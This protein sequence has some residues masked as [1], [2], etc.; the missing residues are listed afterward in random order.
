MKNIL[1]YG[2]T[3]RMV[4]VMIALSWPIIRFGKAWSNKPILKWII[5]PFF[6]RPYNELSSIPVVIPVNVSIDPPES[7]PIPLRVLERLV[8]DIEDRFILH[9][10]ICRSHVKCGNHPRDLG[11]M[12]LGPAIDRMHPTHGRRV[13]AD[14]AVAHVRRAAKE[15][16]VPNIAHVWIDP[17]SFGLTRFQ[18][19][20]FICFCDDCCCIYRKYMTARGPNLDKAY[21]KIPGISIK[22]NAELCNG[23]GDCVQRCFLGE[24]KIEEGKSVTNDNAC[25]GCGKCVAVCTKGARTLVI[26]D[27]KELYRRVIARVREMSDV[28]IDSNVKKGAS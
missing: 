15:G 18:K 1:R 6:K 22:L 12:A 11:C 25:A 3:K 19:L 9:E 28:A 13:T 7:V 24:I 27:E 16:L 20:M 21:K 26:P 17:L 5:N 4:K 23:C 10:C 14:E 2:P 8:T